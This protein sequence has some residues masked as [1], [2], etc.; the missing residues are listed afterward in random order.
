MTTQLFNAKSQQTQ[1]PLLSACYALSELFLHQ[2]YVVIQTL[3][4]LLSLYTLGFLSIHGARETVMA[5]TQYQPVFMKPL[6]TF[7]LFIAP[8]IAFVSGWSVSREWRDWYQ[9]AH[10][11]AHTSVTPAKELTNDR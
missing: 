9:Q 3:F 7:A 6:L 4:L 8:G 11:A 2:L 5:I 10:A 1:P